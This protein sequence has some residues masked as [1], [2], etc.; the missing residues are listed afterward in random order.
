M[1]SAIT[2][3]AVSVGALAVSYSQGQ[4]AKKQAD[5]QYASS[6][7]AFQNDI[8]AAVTNAR[9]SYKDNEQEFAFTQAKADRDI[10]NQIN[11]AWEILGSDTEYQQMTAVLKQIINNETTTEELLKLKD[12]TLTDIRSMLLSASIDSAYSLAMA[13]HSADYYTT[14]AAIDAAQKEQT[15][16][17]LVAFL[18]QDINTIRTALQE[19]KEIF[20]V[21]KSEEI[22]KQVLASSQSLAVGNSTTRQLMATNNKLD[23][24]QQ[25]RTREMESAIDKAYATQTR[26]AQDTSADIQNIFNTSTTMAS[27]E[28]EQGLTQVS[29]IINRSNVDR[30]TAMQQ[31]QIGSEYI[32]NITDIANRNIAESANLDIQ[33]N[34]DRTVI[35]V[36]AALENK[37]SDDLARYDQFQQSQMMTARSLLQ[38]LETKRNESK[39]KAGVDTEIRLLLTD[40]EMRQTFAALQKSGTYD[41]DKMATT[42]GANVNFTRT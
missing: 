9:W 19:A 30:E 33:Q 38:S 22:G 12:G 42:V 14:K 32:T 15:L 8:Q 39:N 25:Q 11:T 34:V 2:A 23:M 1:S 24:L 16:Q 37:F 17:S 27:R 4:E 26:A 21:E 31:L 29:R 18:D 10:N 5:K 36:N 40:P 13:Q 3:V 7:A 20:N 28:I 35:N 41:I 6:Q